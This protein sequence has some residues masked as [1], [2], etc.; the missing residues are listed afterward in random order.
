MSLMSINFLPKA[1]FPC[2]CFPIHFSPNMLC[3]DYCLLIKTLLDRDFRVDPLCVMAMA[4]TDKNQ[5]A[6][7]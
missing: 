4:L 6:K 7:I 1:R 2:F 3:Y 5:T